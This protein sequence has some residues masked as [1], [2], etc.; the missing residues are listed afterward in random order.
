MK[1]ALRT[2]LELKKKGDIPVKKFHTECN[3]A[4]VQVDCFLFIS[5]EKQPQ[6]KMEIGGV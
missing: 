5:S 2:I 4:N 1:N 6:H 3:L